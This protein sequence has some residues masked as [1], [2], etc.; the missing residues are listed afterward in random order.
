MK[1][2]CRLWSRWNPNLWAVFPL[3]SSSSLLQRH[4]WRSLP[5]A[6]GR[7]RPTAHPSTRAP[8]DPC[9]EPGGCNWLPPAAHCSKQNTCAAG[10]LSFCFWLL[11]GI[12]LKTDFGYT[13]CLLIILPN[14]WY[15]TA[16]NVV[17]SKELQKNRIWSVK[18]LQISAYHCWWLELDL[19][20]D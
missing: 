1:W 15:N 2:E 14:I 16:E 5:D 9:W 8:A 13:S 20:G 7:S 10:R 11:E 6:E 17:R 12:A 19:A 18:C 4:L 3:W